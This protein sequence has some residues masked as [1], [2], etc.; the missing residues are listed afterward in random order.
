ML[1]SPIKQKEFE[2]FKLPDTDYADVIICRNEQEITDE[3]GQL[4]Y[5][6]DCNQFRTEL[7]KEIIESNL[8]FYFS[9][10][11]ESD[12]DYPKKLATLEQQLNNTQ[13]ALCDIYELI[14]A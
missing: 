9:F 11:P 14:N 5:Q 3:N 10:I 13:L 4:M 12:V 1:Q 8:D 2:Y 6:Y 7:S